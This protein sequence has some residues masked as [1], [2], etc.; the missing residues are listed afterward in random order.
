MVESKPIQFVRRKQLAIFTLFVSVILMALGAAGKSHTIGW[1]GFCLL[2]L[3]I[4]LVLSCEPG[5][6]EQV[7]GGFLRVILTWGVIGIV[8]LLVIGVAY[9][10]LMPEKERLAEKYHV[11]QRAVFIDQKPHGCDFGDAPLGNKHCHFERQE[12]VTK[13]E[14]G[15]VTAVYVTWEK[16]E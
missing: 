14:Q 9:R 1:I 16:V 7:F 10:W 3:A 6:L 8:G 2:A 12:A 15:K 11:Q 4:G 5:L 13:D